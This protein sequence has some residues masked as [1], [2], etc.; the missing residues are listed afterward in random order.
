[1]LDDSKFDAVKLEDKMFDDSM[2]DDS[3]A[4]GA[5]L[6]LYTGLRDLPTPSISADFEMR[7]MAALAPRASVWQTGWRAMLRPALPTALCTLTGML[8]LLR[9][10]EQAP[11]GVQA[12]RTVVVARAMGNVLP[13]A[14]T[15]G[16]AQQ[17]S[18]LGSMDTFDLNSASLSLLSRPIRRIPDKRG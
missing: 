17:E 6:A 15:R 16:T 2:M 7:I 13:Q 18:S 11:I 8:L 3:E 4:A 9:Q 12:S 5:D 1:M 14:G 10:A